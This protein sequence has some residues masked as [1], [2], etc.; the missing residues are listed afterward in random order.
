LRYGIS[1]YVFVLLLLMLSD[2]LLFPLFK[3]VLRVAF[4]WHVCFLVAAQWCAVFEQYYA[5]KEH[6]HIPFLHGRR[7]GDESGE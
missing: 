2:F 4:L 7:R 1:S 5:E 3:L 6:I